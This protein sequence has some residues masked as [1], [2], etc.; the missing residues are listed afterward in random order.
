MK[1]LFPSPVRPLP[2]DERRSNARHLLIKLLLNHRSR[3]SQYS[4]SEQ[5]Y[6]LQVAILTALVLIIGI[7]AF[8]SRTGSGLF[9][10]IDQSLNREARDVAESA[11]TDFQNALNRVENRYLL[12]AGTGQPWI[13]SDASIRNPC[14]STIDS[15]GA[16]TPGTST[17]VSQATID[18]YYPSTN[19][20]PLDSS[21][22]AAQP[23]KSFKIESIEYKDSNRINYPSLSVPLPYNELLRGG[24]RA[25][26]RVTVVGKVR[27]NGVESYSRVAREFEVVPKC[28]GRSFGRNVYGGVNWGR[29]STSCTINQGNS[30]G[31]GLVGALN[32]GNT[33]GSNNQLDVRDQNG[34]LITKAICWNGSTN[35]ELNGTPNPA[36]TN[37]QLRIGGSG[38][39]TGISF[40]PTPFDLSLPNWTATSQP[41]QPNASAPLANSNLGAGTY[42]TSNAGVSQ[43]GRKTVY[44]FFD[45]SRKRLRKCLY[46]NNTVTLGGSI[47][48]DCTYLSDSATV[49]PCSYK[50]VSYSALGGGLAVS[51]DG[52]YA[53]PV[54][55]YEANCRLKNMSSGNNNV[56]IDTSNAK[57]NIYFDD[58]TY[59]GEYMGG[60]GSTTFRRVH[61]RKTAASLDN[62]NDLRGNVSCNDEVDLAE[63][64]VKCSSLIAGCSMNYD[65]SELLNIYA[66]G[67]G[68]FDLNGS[69]AT[70]GFNLIAPRASVELRGG[71]SSDPNFMGRLWADD[72][73]MNGNVKLRTL[74]TNPAFCK[75]EFGGV[76][77]EFCPPTGLSTLFDFIARSFSHASGF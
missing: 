4:S 10:V 14:T 23:T 49:D 37:N 74:S 75:S 3:K 70:I 8:A 64:Q 45:A 17:P 71:G 27:K 28:C 60:G 24:T 32:G 42:P 58:T 67:S 25:L 39:S 51:S 16:I 7:A 62:L 31:N 68:D 43:G 18:R 2:S 40:V 52:S 44:I 63:Y 34:N 22:L 20:K 1:R 54:P 13:A 36:C 69:Q 35:P 57:V 6:I 29:D 15:S 50:D 72:I 19:F 30:T 33:T 61:C 41:S 48:T 73:Y 21:D 26:L 59:T 11:I 66:E 38:Q 53:N 55:Y 12:V 56:Y 46:P 65:M 9:G 76:G 47:G 77:D 5:G